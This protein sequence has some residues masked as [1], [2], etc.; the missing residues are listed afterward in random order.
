M[1]L[2]VA[3][4]NDHLGAMVVLKDF[5]HGAEIVRNLNVRFAPLC[6]SFT[7]PYDLV[8]GE[9]LRE[10][11]PEGIVVNEL[12]LVIVT[13]QQEW[14]SL[15]Q[16]SI[17]YQAIV[18]DLLWMWLVFVVQLQLPIGLL[19]QSRRTG[20]FAAFPLYSSIVTWPGLSV[21][22]SIKVQNGFF[23]KRQW[24]PLTGLFSF[25]LLFGLCSCTV[26]VFGIWTLLFNT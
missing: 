19:L 1:H 26:A 4:P 18:D 15:S 14:N 24:F 5:Q 17:Q 6:L 2:L 23:A 12:F 22:I 11:I 8:V 20:Y 9:L 7:R 10:E 25:D 3:S 13:R 16:L 21:L